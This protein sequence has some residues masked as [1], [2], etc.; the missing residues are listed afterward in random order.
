MPTLRELLHQLAD[1]DAQIADA[2]SNE[3]AAV[4]VNIKRA[5]AENGLTPD[6]I[7]DIP[8]PQKRT[9]PPA[10]YRDPE[11]GATWS[12]RGREPAWIAGQNR[13]RFL[14]STVGG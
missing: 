1:L 9:K 8:R 7:F 3:L 10:K 4:I 5:I 12:G 11:T 6:D 2:R 13:T 14:N